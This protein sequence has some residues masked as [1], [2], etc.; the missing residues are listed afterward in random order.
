LWEGGIGFDVCGFEIA[1][2]DAAFVRGLER[3]D[4][5]SRDFQTL[6]DR[7]P[8]DSGI[9]VINAVGQRVAGHELH[10]DSQWLLF[11]P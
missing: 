11:E 1:V 3:V 7:K 2:N 10:H 6:S 4:D 8:V 9:R 5:L